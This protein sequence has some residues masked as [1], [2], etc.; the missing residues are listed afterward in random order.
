M[1]RITLSL[2]ALSSLLCVAGCAGN[3]AIQPV[4]PVAAAPDAHPRAGLKA[5]A[6]ATAEDSANLAHDAWDW[7]SAEVSDTY[8][9]ST[10][11]QCYEHGK[12]DVHSLEDAK[13][14]AMKCWNDN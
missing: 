6:V 3:P 7:V 8:H 1:N 9:N 4:A 11:A 5:D 2:I 12:A 10:M 13:K 14:L